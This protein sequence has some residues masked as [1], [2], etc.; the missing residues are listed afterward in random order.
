VAS[1]SFSPNPEQRF[2]YVGDIMNSAVWIL[3]RQTGEIVGRF[4]RRGYNGGQFMLLHI[5]VSDS[6]GNIYTGEVAASGR[7]QKFIPVS[8]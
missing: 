5:A 6:Q 8:Q 4:G 2:I 7:I 3:N 1:V